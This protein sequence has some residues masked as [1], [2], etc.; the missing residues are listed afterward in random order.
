MVRRHNGLQ[1]LLAAAGM[2]VLIFDSASAAEGAA[3]GVELCIKTVI[4]SLFP[5]FVLSSVLLSK[6]AFSPP[7]FLLKA[8]E[9]PESAASILIPA[10]LGGYPVGA[11]CVGDLY[12]RKQLRR[13]DAERLL[14]FCSNAGPS[15]L[16]GM[17]AA[18]FPERKTA[19]AIWMV[20]IASV[21]L[22][23][24]AVPGRAETKPLS[25]PERQTDTDSVIASAAK[26]MGLVCCWV[27]LFRM[28][29]TFLSRWVLW[30]LP[31]WARVL[32]TG[33]LELVNGCC[34]LT[35]IGDIRIRFILCCCMLS[36]GGIC[37]LLQTASV[38][39]GLRLRYYFRGKLL[40]ALFSFLLSW[41]I[42]LGHG[43]IPAA[44]LTVLVLLF[45][46]IQ[47]RYG[48]LRVFPV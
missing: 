44:I 35:E 30:L 38:T 29:L 21:L 48:N 31:P 39:E 9:I 36:F 27:I 19:W 7:G 26:A 47:N 2:L 11:K 22:T 41:G 15:F 32:V 12:R 10:F 34:R 43:L 3:A 45:R 13:A 33:S 14:G 37:V 28:I 4:P 18:C 23:A 25:Q 17:A 1:G 6:A 8:L 20:H 24:L 40:Q 42:V 16:F 5:F 46:K